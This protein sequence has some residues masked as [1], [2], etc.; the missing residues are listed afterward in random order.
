MHEIL[1]RKILPTT[2]GAAGVPR[3]RWTLAEFERLTELGFFTDED[4]IELIGGELVPLAP[5]TVCHETVRCELLNGRAMRGLPTGV[6][7]AAALGWRLSEDT[8]LEP[9]FLLYPAARR[10]DI[11]SLPPTQVLLAIEVAD[12][13]LEF[14]TTFKARLYAAL[15]VREYWV[16]NAV[17]PM[18]HVYRGPSATGYAEARAVP[19]NVP[20]IPLLVPALSVTLADLRI[21]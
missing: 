14:D 7:V 9:D 3:L 2:Q 10:R 1:Q 8:Y 21:D 6:G 11:P 19:P 4:H 16:V 12:L 17:S 5:K 20:L 15:G 18:T 13:S